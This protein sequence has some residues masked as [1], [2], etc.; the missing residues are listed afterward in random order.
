MSERRNNLLELRYSV[1]MDLYRQAAQDN[2]ASS[3][4]LESLVYKV[5]GADRLASISLSMDPFWQFPK[6]STVKKIN[7]LLLGSVF[8]VQVVPPLRYRVLP[9]IRASTCTEY[10]NRHVDS[11]SGGPTFDGHAWHQGALAKTLSQDFRS[12]LTKFVQSPVSGFIRDTTIRTRNGYLRG[13][14]PWF[15]DHKP[16]WSVRKTK[17]D[18]SGDKVPVKTQGECE[19]YFPRIVSNQTLT[20]I[21]GLKSTTETKWL[22]AQQPGP[23]WNE[24][25]QYE[26]VTSRFVGPSVGV[27]AASMAS[28]LSSLQTATRQALADNVLRMYAKC[29]P[30]RRS[31]L[32]V[33]REIGEIKDMPQLVNGSLR[34]WKD[35]EDIVG[36]ATFKKMQ[37][38]PGIWN[39]SFRLQL[40]S[41]LKRV[42][43]VVS[44]DQKAS[45]AYLAFKFGWLQLVQSAQ[46]LASMPER[47]T[48][49]VNYLISR[50]GKDTTLST[51]IKIPLEGVAAP[52]ILVP[53]SIW[54]TKR[55]ESTNSDAYARIR[56][57]VNSG[58]LFPSIELPR[59]RA[60]LYS[61]TLGTFPTPSVIYDL[62]PFTWIVDWVSGLGSYLHL[63]E[64][65]SFSG[66]MPVNYGFMTAHVN[67][68]FSHTL[69]TTRVEHFSRGDPTPVN[70][71]RTVSYDVT[72]EYRR[73]GQVAVKYYLRLAIESLFDAKLYNGLNLTS[74]QLPVLQALFS[75]FL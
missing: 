42:G 37:S 70:A 6:S 75:R 15:F 67:C 4:G 31:S 9:A 14:T 27:D 45:D 34:L 21:S 3:K 18:G 32:N 36:Q 10:A 62:I 59:L 20:S 5:F 66:E 39:R 30:S 55:S 49:S 12:T 72:R 52:G 69:N 48:R 28:M 44:A 40:S 60:N 43:V 7:P 71:P 61:Q 29:L 46:R 2:A 22:A 38:E 74:D 63:L 58:I 54:E 64:Q 25:D 65:V 68:L 33:S 13:D 56:C 1:A 35:I 23:L 73:T 41:P 8:P 24:S 11:Y 57:V 17:R 50:N 51:E 47:V 16:G 26:F 53:F 19:L